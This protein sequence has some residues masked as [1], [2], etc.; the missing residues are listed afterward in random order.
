MAQPRRILAFAVFFLS[1]ALFPCRAIA[2]SGTVTDD[3]FI[4]THPATELLNLKGQGI[5]LI[6]AGSSSTVGPLQVGSSTTLIKFQLLS[7]LPPS[8]AAAN[9]AKATLKLYFS[10]GVTPVGGID[11]YPVLSP[12]NESTVSPS[13]PPTMDTSSPDSVTNIAVGTTNS[14]L[15]VDITQLV[16]DWLNGSAN[17]GLDNDGIALVANTATTYAVFD[18]KEDIVTSHEPRLEI[19]LANRG[20][21]GP[22]GPQGNTGPAG[23]AGPTGSTGSAGNAATVAVGMTTTGPAG[24]SAAVL[25]GGTSNAAVLNFI[26]PQ[27]APGI[28]GPQGAQGPIGV[29]NRSQWNS[30]NTYNPNDAVFDSASYWLALAVNSNSEPSPANTNWQLLAGGL[31]NRGQWVTTNNYN[32]NDAVSDQGSFWLALQSIPA[33]TPNSEPSPTNTS[34]QL[35]AAMGATGAAGP[36]GA[37]GPQGNMGLQGPPG[38]PG[39]NPVGAALTTTPNTF[40]GDQSIN[41]NLILGA[42]GVGI[43]FPDGSIQTTAAAVPSGF[44]IIGSSPN[45]PPGFTGAGILGGTGQWFSGPSVPQS[46]DTSSLATLNNNIYF[47]GLHPAGGVIGGAS[48][49]VWSWNPTGGSWTDLTDDTTG[50]PKAFGGATGN[51]FVWA[52]E[53]GN[54]QSSACPYDTTHNVWAF[55]GVCKPLTGGLEALTT[56]ATSGGFINGAFVSDPLIWTFGGLDPLNFKSVA[57]E[58]FDTASDVVSPSLGAPIKA[59]GAVLGSDVYVLGGYTDSTVAGE[60][61]CNTATK[62]AFFFD[63]STGMSKAIADIPIPTYG[64]T[65]VALNGQI[66]LMGGIDCTGVTFGQLGIPAT[67]DVFI[68]D[69]PSNTWSTAPSMPGASQTLNAVTVNGKIYVI[70]ATGGAVWIFAPPVYLFTKN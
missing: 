70:D 19:V 61:P 34:W 29:N 10:P 53:G 22:Q 23:P 25:N 51:G 14:F 44:Q 50:F 3:A 57:A 39:T 59:A 4:A 17:G 46:Y 16:K 6:V 55:G 33:N 45:P 32:V 26:I 30:A 1:L 68:Y 58:V 13:S 41:G 20:P 11:L 31:V 66:Y 8:T 49:S 65:A 54:D 64:G 15:V 63:A 35:L 5:S 12:W 67:S 69:P 48:R 18:S 40:S 47:V 52:F 2:Q 37:Q 36:A 38:P 9:V 56:V 27:G 7:S 24:S 21:Q 62:R 42:P 60:V 43:T 28:Q